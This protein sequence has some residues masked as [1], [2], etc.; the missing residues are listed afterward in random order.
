MADKRTGVE[1]I[2]VSHLEAKTGRWNVIGTAGDE[3]LLGV[4][5]WRGAWRAY[6]FHAEP[7][8]DPILASNCLRQLADFCDEKNAEHREELARRKVASLGSWS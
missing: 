3:D 6:V 5:K 7:G 4:V 2:D 1:F 8:S